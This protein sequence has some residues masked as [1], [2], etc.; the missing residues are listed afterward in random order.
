[1]TPFVPVKHVANFATRLRPPERGATRA[2]IF[3]MS[4][5]HQSLTAVNVVFT[6]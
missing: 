1:M 5:T 3:N 2:W 6:I 4:F